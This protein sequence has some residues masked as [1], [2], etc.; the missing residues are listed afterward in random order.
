MYGLN[1][2]ANLAKNLFAQVHALVVA[3]PVEDLDHFCRIFDGGVVLRNSGAKCNA[4]FISG[5]QKGRFIPEFGLYFY[6]SHIFTITLTPL[7]QDTRPL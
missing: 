6:F 5:R 3:Q 4:Q 2:L 1:L 7:A